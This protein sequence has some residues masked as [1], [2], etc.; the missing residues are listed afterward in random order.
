MKILVISKCP[1]HPTTAGNRNFIKAQCELLLTLGHDVHFL[2]VQELPLTRKGSCI[3]D[4]C[5]YWGNKLH[6]YDYKWAQKVLTCVVARFRRYCCNGFYKRFDQYPFR[7]HSLVR[8]IQQ[9]EQFDC[10]IV[11][12][13]YL[14][15]LFKYVH[16]PL[17]GLVTHDY[18]AYKNLHV[19][20]NDVRQ[21]TAHEEAMALQCCPHLFALNT[22]E[23][24]Y[25]K[26]LAP[27]SEVYNVFSA[28]QYHPQP[29]K[30]NHDILFLSGPNVYNINGLRWFLGK[31][32]PDIQQAFPDV[33][34][35]IAGAICKE[36]K[37]LEGKENIELVGLVDSPDV[38]YASAD[39]A[40]NPTYQGTGLKIKTF[41]AISYDKVVL[42]HPHS[43]VG[44]FQQD[45]APLF[46]S[47]EPKEWIDFLRTIWNN[48][49][50][51]N[52]I[53]S[54]DGS[55]IRCMN[56][57]VESEYKRFFSYKKISEIQK[58]EDLLYK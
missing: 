49:D 18:F 38:F 19:G 23:A 32:F 3:S 27:C 24:E 10:C 37:D 52:K 56:D 12:Y 50:Q 53:K 22:G 8:K 26:R 55:Y 46:A 44:I 21:I 33:R 9:K 41:E 4:M 5:K 40:I 42:A 17:E 25:F 1:T 13:Y 15:K 7:L 36:L 28:Y 48:P 57:F 34:L 51:I 11:Q 47:V 43:K 20:N 35:R 2:Y 30:S 39:V 16:F 58:K 6:I 14:A 45:S 31:I 29:I 54:N